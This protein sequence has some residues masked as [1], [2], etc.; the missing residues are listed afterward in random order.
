MTIQI[1]PTVTHLVNNLLKFGTHLVGHLF[2]VYLLFWVTSSKSINWL[3][4]GKDIFCNY[5]CNENFDFYYIFL[6][7]FP[8]S[9]PVTSC[10]GREARGKYEPQCVINLCVHLWIVDSPGASVLDS[11]NYTAQP[12][13]CMHPFAHVMYLSTCLLL[14]GCIVL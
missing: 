8:W 3:L 10:E 4:V 6:C 13:P 1:G 14:L 9:K 12:F 2:I 11:Y 5:K 7:F